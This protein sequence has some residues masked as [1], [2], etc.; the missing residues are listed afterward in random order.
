[1]LNNKLKVLKIVRKNIENLRG[2][3]EFFMQTFVKYYENIE[4]F[5]KHSKTSQNIQNFATNFFNIFTQKFSIFFNPHTQYPSPVDDFSQREHL[6][7]RL[8]EYVKTL[9]KVRVIRCESKPT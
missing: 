9:P 3:I 5:K 7:S 2:N 1:L 8:D 4:K 6:K